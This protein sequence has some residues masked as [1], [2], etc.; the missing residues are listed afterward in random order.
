MVML[1]FTNKRNT[2]K[3]CLDYIQR[4]YGNDFT[5]FSIDFKA[6]LQ[7]AS[8]S[9]EIDLELNKNKDMYLSLISRYE[10]VQKLQLFS[11]LKSDLLDAPR[12]VKLSYNLVAK[13]ITS[14]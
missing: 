4:V 5:K 11:D 9:E 2:M 10:S 7:G 12:N 3:E 14:K 8:I 13:Y 1:E 6:F